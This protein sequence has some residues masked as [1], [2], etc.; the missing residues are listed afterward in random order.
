M[1]G[2]FREQGRRRDEDEWNRDMQKMGLVLQSAQQGFYTPRHEDFGAQMAEKYPDF[3]PMYAE[4][5]KEV[6]KA[7]TA[8]RQ[9]IGNVGRRFTDAGLVPGL[10]GQLLPIGRQA[11][12]PVTFQQIWES[13]DPMTKAA[14][15]EQTGMKVEHPGY[16]GVQRQMGPL[17]F[18]ISQRPLYQPGLTPDQAAGAR[19]GA[20]LEETPTED[21]RLT[22]QEGQLDVAQ[23]RAATSQQQEDR[24]ARG[25]TTSG[26]KVRTV[27]DDV[28]DA[29]KDFDKR[30]TYTPTQEGERKALLRHRPRRMLSSHAAAIETEI[31]GSGLP[32]Q[33][34]QQIRARVT[35]DWLDL[36]SGGFS[37][38]QAFDII[39]HQKVRQ[40]L[41]DLQRGYPATMIHKALFGGG[42]VGGQVA[43]QGE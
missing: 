38:Q 7:G 20:K 15:A 22:L 9:A 42:A 34:Q 30:A 43:A 25:G 1:I 29:I 6:A 8:G 2:M 27:A 37:A 21:R 28:D 4:G 19:Y 31:A 35:Q 40:A 17:D 16:F 36:T 14:I 33:A 18:R 12:P 5:L 23:T 13:A 10:S 3:G 11:A 32:P 26:G 41:G 39:T 24:L